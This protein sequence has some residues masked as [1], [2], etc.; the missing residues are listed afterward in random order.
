MS[1]Q[2]QYKD[3][4]PDEAYA[5]KPEDL[6]EDE[7]IL[8]MGP[9]HPSTHG[10]LRIE[11]K[12][13]GEV[14]KEARPHIGYLHRNF[15]KHAENIDYQGVIPFT[16][17]LDYVASMNNSLTYAV[18]VEKLM[19]IEL[20]ERVQAIRV[21]TSEL[22][23]VASHL[24]AIGTY[25]L[26]I[27][28]FTPFLHCFREREKILDLFEWLCGAR[29][30]YN[31]N[32][33]GGV[34]HDFPDTW[35]DRALVFLDQFEP[36]IDELNDLLSYNKIFTKRTAE[37]GIILPELAVGY[38]LTGPNLR[39]SGIKWDIRKED[40]YCGYEQYEFDV[41]VGQGRYG[42]IGSCW[43][44]YYVRVEEMRQSLRITRQAI[45]KM[46][47]MSKM[48]ASDVR[49]GVP[50]RVKPKPGEAYGRTEAPRGELGF[51][52]VS[53]GSL[54][55]YRVKARSPCFVAMSLFHELARGEMIADMAAIIGSLD[56]VL[57]EIDR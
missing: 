37:V 8:N 6:E 20:N 25:G 31:Y 39:G 52:V 26:D 54:I 56:I 27:G 48:A 57:G 50:K 11:L 51:Y 18:A 24:L 49:E 33:I 53:D 15:E 55:P 43:D 36:V 28:A 44:R 38:A 13:D 10:V 14:I 23:R 9:Q 30:L 19:G 21:I 17:R 12:T 16:D 46:S 22:Q 35:T 34:S 5:F 4:E 1:T 41:P 3:L 2:T 45:E 32:W 42:P 40:P 29:L 47:K 7:M